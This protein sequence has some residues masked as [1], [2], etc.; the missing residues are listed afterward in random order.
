LDGTRSTASLQEELDG[1][2]YPGL[3]GCRAMDILEKFVSACGLLDDAR[4]AT[5]GGKARSRLTLAIPLMSSARLKFLTRFTRHAYGGGRAATLLLLAVGAA[6]QLA[7]WYLMRSEWGAEGAPSG[8]GGVLL[9]VAIALA[10]VPIHELGHLSACHRF[11]CEA[12]DLGLGTYLVFPVMYVDLS[13]AWALPR[14][15]RVVIDAGGIYF[16]FIGASL[17]GAAHLLTGNRVFGLLALG[18]LISASI[19]VN[20]LLKLDGYWCVGDWVGIPNLHQEA[21]RAL[22][23]CVASGL[24]L[25]TTA[26][27][28]SYEGWRKL[29]LVVFGALHIVFLVLVCWSVVLFLPG[30]LWWLNWHNLSLFVNL[31]EAEPLSQKWWAAVPKAV[32]HLLLSLGVL[33]LI[34]RLVVQALAASLTTARRR[35]KRRPRVATSQPGSYGGGFAGAQINENEAA[36]VE[37]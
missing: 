15:R 11:G 36:R 19:N 4:I 30:V 16:Q 34:V 20:P 14:M 37:L 17:L 9:V 8:V 13:A 25:K 27:A 5:T 22:W 31:L 33:V 18:Y 2:D 29:F 23:G 6:V 35:L 3:S 26:R 1:G 21:R 10:C 32:G 24:G 28:I 12:G 7:S